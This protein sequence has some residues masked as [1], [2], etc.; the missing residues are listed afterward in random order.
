MKTRRAD[1][2]FPGNSSIL[3]SPH[4]PLTLPFRWLQFHV[5]TVKSHQSLRW[6]SLCYF[7]FKL[8]YN[9]FPCCPSK[10]L[11]K[12]ICHFPVSKFHPLGSDCNIELWFLLPHPLVD[13]PSMEPLSSTLNQAIELTFFPFPF[14]FQHP[15]SFQLE[16]WTYSL[17]SLERQ[18]ATFLFLMSCAKS[19]SLLCYTDVSLTGLKAV[20]HALMLKDWVTSPYEWTFLTLRIVWWVFWEKQFDPG[21]GH[22]NSGFLILLLLEG[23]RSSNV[24]VPLQSGNYHNARF[25][26]ILQRGVL[27]LNP[28]FVFVASLLTKSLAGAPQ[29]SLRLDLFTFIDFC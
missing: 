17:L 27:Q 22:L 21:I 19:W 24:F 2:F 28:V 16:L 6:W 8:W 9:T 13:W 25:A 10:P 11:R 15:R 23:H 1:P 26:A 5:Q 4:F 18:W 14:L 29:V 3:A 12:S 7:V 20:H